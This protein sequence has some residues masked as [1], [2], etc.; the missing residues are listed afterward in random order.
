[1][2]CFTCWTLFTLR[3]NRACFYKCL[4]GS[5]RQPNSD[6]VQLADHGTD[7]LEVVGSNPIGDNF[8]FYCSATML[9]GSCHDCRFCFVW[10]ANREASLL[11]ADRF[12]TKHFCLNMESLTPA[13]SSWCSND[14]QRTLTFHLPTK[15]KETK[16]NLFW[17]KLTFV[18]L[19]LKK[20]DW[21]IPLFFQKPKYSTLIRD[22]FLHYL[23]THCIIKCRC[24]E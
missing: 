19:H 15:R 12:K 1:M 22:T 14:L 11:H 6:L 2:H 4:N 10:V 21:F 20:T 7:N 5:H 16:N 9:A 23:F 17:R 8:L 3:I 18:K 13:S 24:S